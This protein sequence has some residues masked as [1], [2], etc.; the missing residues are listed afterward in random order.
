MSRGSEEAECVVVG[1]RVGPTVH[2]VLE[3][4][5]AGPRTESMSDC[6]M[7]DCS[8]RDMVLTLIPHQDIIQ[9]DVLVQ[10]PSFPD[11][12]HHSHGVPTNGRDVVRI[13]GN[14]S[15]FE[16]AGDV[17][18]ERDAGDVFEQDALDDLDLASIA[19]YR[20]I[21]CDNTE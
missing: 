5:S 21:V 10:Y 2:P 4:E 15:G 19:G 6:S 7:S 1:E 20:K 16:C 9:P 11:R 12:I 13:N 3:T 18:P 8:C 14:G 17:V